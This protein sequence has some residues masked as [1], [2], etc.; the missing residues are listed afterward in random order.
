MGGNPHN[1]YGNKIIQNFNQTN[2]ISNNF[3][4]SLT[5]Y[6][7]TIVWFTKDCAI[8]LNL[9]I[10]IDVLRKYSPNSTYDPCL[11]CRVHHCLTQL[12]ILAWSID[13][14]SYL[15]LAVPLFWICWCQWPP[16]ED[17]LWLAQE[18]FDCAVWIDKCKRQEDI[19]YFY[20]RENEI[21]SEIIGNPKA[22]IGLAWSLEHYQ[23]PSLIPYRNFQRM[24]V[25]TRT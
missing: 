20:W 10:L 21:N 14:G 5:S 12:M 15:S 11:A 4:F 13:V 3:D 17:L 8:K 25:T 2:L 24:T 1:I 22:G 23:A 9:L 18:H 19:P 6:S 7:A 16:L